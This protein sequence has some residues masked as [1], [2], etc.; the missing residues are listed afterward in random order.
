MPIFEEL[1]V[2][3]VLQGHNHLYERTWPAR[4]G[5]VAAKSYDRPVAPV[6]VTTGGGGDWLYP[7]EQPSQ[8][9]VAMRESVGQHSIL[10]LDGGSLRVDAIRPDGS[11]L[12]TFTIVKDVP[13][14]SL[15]DDAPAPPVPDAEPIAGGPPGTPGPSGGDGAIDPGHLAGGGAGGGCQS[16]TAIGLASLAGVVLGLRLLVRRRP[17]RR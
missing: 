13:P 4:G 3:L 9:W 14:P 5:K 15:P 16:G 7:I 1:G 12:D 6:Y 11:V 17:K 8:P 10:T 2:D